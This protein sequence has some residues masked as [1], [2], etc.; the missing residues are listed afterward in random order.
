M[1]VFQWSTTAANN[2]AQPGIPMAEGMMPAQLNDSIRQLMADLAGIALVPSAKFNGAVSDGVVNDAA[3]VAAA[4]AAGGF[5]V[6][7]GRTR[8][9]TTMTIA[10]NVVRIP[11][12]GTLLIDACVLTINGAVVAELGLLFECVNGGSV[13]LSP[14]KNSFVYPEWW[15]AVVNDATAPVQAANLV[16]FNACLISGP[17]NMQLQAADYF[18]S[19]IWKINTPHRTI[20][21]YSRHQTITGD[22]TRIVGNGGAD[23]VIQVGPDTQP[24]GGINAFLQE[25]ELADFTVTRGAV[26]IAPA[27]GFAAPA[28]IRMQYTLYCKLSRISSSEHCNG[29]WFRGTVQTH[30]EYCMASRSITG[31][32]PANDFFNGFFIDGSLSI[33]AAAGNASLFIHKGNVQI[34]GAP[35]LTI[36]RGYHL[37]NTWTDTFL[38]KCET[39]NLGR[40]VDADASSQTINGTQDLHIRAHIFDACNEYGIIIHEGNAR[41]CVNIE[42]GYIA[43][44]AAV[45]FVAAI[46]AVNQQGQLGIM[47]GQVIG[48]PNTGVGAGTIGVYING[49]LGVS[50]MGILLSDCQR[51]IVVTG[52]S[53]CD[54]IPRISNYVVAITQGAVFC[55]GTNTRNSYRPRI[56]GGAGA[57]SSGVNFSNLLNTFSEVNCSDIDAAAIGGG[58]GNK[59]L[60][61]AVQIVATGTFNTNCLAVG[62]MT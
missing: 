51:P 61:N 17:T 48:T 18:L 27:S 30:V 57:I 1:S 22:C 38:D 21:G 44:S 2:G 24:G 3:A 8:I 12:M 37:L 5:S 54:I 7:R 41:S 16:A 39:T 55:S 53:H 19:A 50:V 28:G 20:R 34:G 4:S 11:G 9:A 35:A 26:P 29:Y 36:S 62:I 33:G 14:A 56:K 46:A 59:L 43:P 45:G 25:V 15:G 49:S 58:S 40:A 32:T 42:G 60:N 13:V 6:P 52:S 10:A 31:G 47:G 23:T